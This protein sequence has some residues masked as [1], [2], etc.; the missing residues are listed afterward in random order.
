MWFIDAVRQMKGKPAMIP[1][2]TRMDFPQFLVEWGCKVGAEI[3]VYKG[4][5]T[6]QFCKAGLRMYAI[7]PWIAFPGQGRTQQV[8]ERQDFLFSH[9]C[10]T[11]AP[12]GMGPGSGVFRMTSMEAIE[13]F[14]DGSL[15]FVYIDGDHSFRHIAADICEW[16]KKVRSGGVVSGHDYFNTRATARNIVCNVQAVVDAYTKAFEI[17]NWFVFGELDPEKE[18]NRK[19]RF[20]SWMWIKK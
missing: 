10:R 19:E 8:Q 12:Y 6:E 2:C 7:D 13:D 1:G 18:P 15:D 9:A 20:L 4:E 5:F 14:S 17:D 11:L 3:G 16:E